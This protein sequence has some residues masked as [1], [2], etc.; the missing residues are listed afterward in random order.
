[1]QDSDCGNGPGNQRPFFCA[2]LTAVPYSQVLKLE[3]IMRLLPP[4][5]AES[6]WLSVK[7]ANSLGGYAARGEASLF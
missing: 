7:L 6:L 3:L 1:L 5:S 2:Y 4:P